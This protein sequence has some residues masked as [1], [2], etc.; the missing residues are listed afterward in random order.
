MSYNNISSI[1]LEAFGSVEIFD[2]SLEGN[3]VTCDCI[4]QK[5]LLDASNSNVYGRCNDTGNSTITRDLKKITCDACS[6]YTCQ[7]Y[8]YCEVDLPYKTPVCICTYGNN[9]HGACRR[10]ACEINRCRNG[11]KCIPTTI[12]T[13]VCVCTE[14]FTGNRCQTQLHTNT[15]PP[16][17]RA[18]VGVS[19][20]STSV[21]VVISISA[22]I[23]G[24]LV[25][26]LIYY[27]FIRPNVRGE[28]RYSPFYVNTNNP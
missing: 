8:T 24:T 7:E 22:F 17:S 11:A 19:S 25:S 18:T 12:T 9:E 23:V 6:T 14:G 5:I 3:P 21:V 1:P 10:P 26:L 15:T 28:L 27:R 13:F 2:F 16:Q 20:L 4:L